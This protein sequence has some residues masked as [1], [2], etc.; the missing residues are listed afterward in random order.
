MTSEKIEIVSPLRLSIRKIHAFV[1]LKQDWVLS[2][3]KQVEAKKKSINNIVRIDCFD[4]ESLL[5]RGEKHKITFNSSALDEIKIE[6]NNQKLTI[7]LPS[8]LIKDTNNSQVRLAI[9]NW[10]KKQ[11]LMIANGYVVLHVS[12]FNLYPRVVRIKTQKSR[13]GS[14]GIHDDINLNWLLIFAP[15]EVMEYVLVHELCHIKERNHS[16]QFWGLVEAHLPDYKKHRNW[17]KEN[18]AGLMQ[19]NDAFSNSNINL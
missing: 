5:F 13:W 6:F 10:L 1:V 3:I 4:G 7:D 18:G 12:K 16:A 9:K 8:H 19:E 17:L 15:A 14:C 11:A 2:A